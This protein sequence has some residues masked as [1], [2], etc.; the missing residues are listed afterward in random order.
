MQHCYAHFNVNV[1]NR[2]D[3]DSGDAGAPVWASR[4]ARR[5][6]FPSSRVAVFSLW[7]GVAWRGQIIDT[8][9]R[10]TCMPAAAW[11]TII[12]Q[13]KNWC[14]L[15][16][17]DFFSPASATNFQTFSSGHLFLIELF[18]NILKKEPSAEMKALRPRNEPG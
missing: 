13:S 6:E 8:C 18:S 12:K 7:R 10:A 11:A 1:K 9:L 3:R 5:I 17:S 15:N 2:T 14:F 16:D 4:G